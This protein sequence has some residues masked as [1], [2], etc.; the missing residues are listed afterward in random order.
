MSLS[1]EALYAKAK[2]LAVTSPD[3]NFLELARAL[4]LLLQRDPEKFR[5][6]WQDARIGRRRAY[7]LVEID[8][9][10]RGLP[11][12]KS[13]LRRIGWTKLQVLAP[14]VKPSNVDQ[15]LDLAEELTAKVLART[16]EGESISAKPH[17][18][19][20]YFDPPE[21]DLLVSALIPYGAILEGRT[22]RGKEQALLALLADTAANKK[23]P[24]K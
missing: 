3:D 16:L 17:C 5:Q 19:L 23:G 15:L 9:A 1:I 24:T 6:L 22:L 11:V 18:V 14:H 13:R 10:F 7:Y 4:N 2:A 8:E 12:P 20:M 21:F